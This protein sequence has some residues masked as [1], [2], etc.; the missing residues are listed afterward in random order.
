MVSPIS[1]GN[2]PQTV[3]MEHSDTVVGTGSFPTINDSA[4]T[5]P[6][7]QSGALTCR[8]LDISGSSSYS[9]NSSLYMSP[10]S[11]LSGNLSRHGSNTLFPPVSEPI[12]GPSGI[13]T[14]ASRQCSNV[15][16]PTSVSRCPS[17][18][19]K[20]GT[21]GSSF[22]CLRTS[23]PEKAVSSPVAKKKRHHRL[24]ALVNTKR[25][26]ASTSTTVKPDLDALR[27]E[28]M[29]KKITLVDLQIKQLRMQLDKSQLSDP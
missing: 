6:L 24:P 1:F 14:G 20:A 12:A 7:I 26:G 28:F 29:V 15:S 10:M 13:L 8:P 2:V 25:N 16:L 21:S 11:D 27:A 4:I 22:S 9:T 5:F 17:G 3:S 19:T 23:T 18:L